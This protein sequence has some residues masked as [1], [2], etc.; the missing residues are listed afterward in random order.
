[1]NDWLPLEDAQE[2]LLAL[3]PAP[4]SEE[5]PTQSALGRI[6]ARDIRARRTQPPADLSA[7]D[8]YAVRGEGPWQVVGESRAG[9]PFA[10]ALASSEAVRISTGAAM[11]EGGESVLIQEEAT[12]DGDTLHAAEPLSSGRHIRRRGF[13]FGEGDTLLEAGCEIG[14]AQI[15]LAMAGGHGS[16]SVAVPPTVAVLD[17]GDELAADPEALG[18]G[19]IPA[20]NGAMI[21]A[22]LAP[23][24]GESRRIGPVAD[25]MDALVRALAEAE[26]CDILVTSGGASVGDHDLVQAAL[27]EWG[28]QLAF[29]KVAIR[30]GK[31]L[32]VAERAVAGRRQVI[33][34]LP[35]N[36]VSSFVTTLLFAVP[37]V[38]ASLGAS[39][40]LP[41]LRTARLAEGLPAGGSRREFLRGIR[42]GGE[43]RRAGSQDSSALR[44]LAAADCLIVR[45]ADAPAAS[46]GEQVRILSLRNG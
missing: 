2:R 28:A 45:P 4:R 18:R 36:P 21:A 23:H 14:A 39:R 6:L 7:M 35:G 3:A 32:M 10:G 11:P 24:V 40:V 38:R 5:V 43:V 1:M 15:A 16:L 37:L 44:A 19:Q 46:A 8:G 20:S 27:R 34:G 29:W 22:L 42:S 25:D 9:S 30:P 17:S 12:R 33:L 31:P 41:E 13:D 26:E